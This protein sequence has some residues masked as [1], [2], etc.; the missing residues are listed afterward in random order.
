MSKKVLSSIKNGENLKESNK[1]QKDHTNKHNHNHIHHNGERESDSKDEEYT[2]KNKNSKFNKNK[3]VKKEID[4]K[5][6][7]Y[8]NLQ[9]KDF[10]DFEDVVKSTNKFDDFFSTGKNQPF[11]STE[12]SIFDLGDEFSRNTKE[13]EDEINEGKKIFNFN[14]NF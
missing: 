8:F 12:K 3:F 9:N 11:D 6:P 1:L 4:Y 7:N 5:N 14:F 2:N 10:N 13:I